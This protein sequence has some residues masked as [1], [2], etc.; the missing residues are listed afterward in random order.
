MGRQ[1]WAKGRLEMSGPELEEFCPVTNYKCHSP[2]CSN[3]RW[4]SPEHLTMF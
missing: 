4:D 2:Q 3:L 1:G